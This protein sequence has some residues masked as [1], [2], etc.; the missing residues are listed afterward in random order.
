MEEFVATL[1]HGFTLFQG[2]IAHL[3][4]TVLAWMWV[5]RIVF[6]AS[7]VF[8]PRPG[9][10]VT[11][12]TMIATALVRFY[13]KGSHPEMPAPEIGAIAHIVLWIPLAIFLLY[14][15]RVHHTTVGGLI[16]RAYPY[17]RIL[18][19]GVLITSLVLDIRDVLT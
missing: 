13:I 8:L 1:V 19:V 15:I 17:W 10:I 12:G 16:D 9:A 4:P 3:P 7:I 2:E 11:L 18:V 14:S 6:A 5:M